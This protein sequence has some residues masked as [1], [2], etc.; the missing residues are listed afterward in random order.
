M[1][2]APTP[3]AIVLQ[4]YVTMYLNDNQRSPFYESLGLNTVEFNMHVLHQTNKTTATIFPQARLRNHVFELRPRAACSAAPLPKHPDYRPVRTSGPS[5]STLYVRL[6]PSFGSLP[7]PQAWDTP[8]PRICSCTVPK[9]VLD[10]A[11]S[12]GI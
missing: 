12:G 1:R 8:A 10:W 6:A 5:P 3:L 9:H 7:R 4:V 11:A 2:S